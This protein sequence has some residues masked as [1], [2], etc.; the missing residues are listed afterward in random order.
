[1]TSASFGQITASN[2]SNYARRAQ[3]GIKLKF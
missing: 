1:M 2:Q 3:I